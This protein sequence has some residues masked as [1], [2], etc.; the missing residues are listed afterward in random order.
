MSKY[1]SPNDP[2]LKYPERNIIPADPSKA[3]T[4]KKI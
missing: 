1:S 3:Y 2:R 4:G